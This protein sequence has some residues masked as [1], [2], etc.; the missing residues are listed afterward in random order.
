MLQFNQTIQTTCNVVEE[1]TVAPG[2]CCCCSCCCCVSTSVNGNAS[3][4]ITGLASN[5]K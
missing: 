4:S 3:S 2:A 1:V 5:G